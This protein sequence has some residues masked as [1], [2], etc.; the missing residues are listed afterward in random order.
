MTQSDQIKTAIQTLYRDLLVGL[1]LKP[2][3]GQK[4]MIATIA[5][6]LL[7][8][9][10]DD[11]G[12]RLGENP[13]CIVEAGT[14][15]GKTMAYVVACL[16]VAQAM[17]KKLVISTATIALQEQIMAQ[18]LP[19]IKAQG[20]VDFTYQLAKGRRRYVCLSRLGS[21]LAQHDAV[22]PNQALFADELAVQLDSDQQ[23]LYQTMLQM[24][25]DGDWD[26]DRDAWQEALP[27]AHWRPVTTDHRGCTNRRCTHFNECPFFQARAGLEQAECIVTNHDLVLADLQLGGGAILPAPEEVIYVFDEG[28]HLADK[29]LRQFTHQQGVRQLLRWYSQVRTGVKRFAK[30][31]QGGGQG[32]GLSVNIQ[33][34]LQELEA[35]MVELERLLEQPAFKAQ[36]DYQQVA[37]FRFTNGVVPDALRTQ[38]T[39]LSLLTKRLIRDL[40]SLYEVVEGVVKGEQQGLEASLAEA[41]LAVTGAWAQN[42][43]SQD[44]LWQSYASID[45]VGEAPMARWIQHWQTPERVDIELA[46]SPILANKL[47]QQNLWQRCFAALITSATLLAVGRFDQLLMHTGLSKNSSM[48]ALAS[49][50]DYSASSL[51][52][53]EDAVEPGPEERFVQALVSA[54]PKHLDMS[55]ASLVLFTSRRVMQQVFSNLSSRWQ[56]VI[57]QQGDSSKQRL[58]EQHRQRIDDGEGSILFGLASFAEGID[59]PG[60]YL[61]HVVITRLPFTVPD[62]PVPAALAEWIEAGGGNAFTQLSVPE[63]SVRLIQATGRLLRN[64]D[65][66]GRITVLDKRLISKR[67]GK[68]LLQALPPYQHLL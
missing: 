40:D 54:L 55:E 68:Q 1:A 22:D 37:S 10:Q 11:D 47:L 14:G 51:T 61:T 5:N 12:S 25:D 15:T 63:A 49:P 48:L 41:Y 62:R 24:L 16:P 65:D 34:H 46:S 43:L 50:F 39:Q 17:G 56:D 52:V 6:H 13:A 18:D 26:G 44:L 9:R 36:D 42:S 58:L 7:A 4:Q 19:A 29:T 33:A 28:H 38:A 57:L 2:R 59:L 67:Y 21:V 53:P 35:A 23:T 66:K 32:A 64:E 30:D 45:E 8:I 3:W 31:W 60:A 20:K 27:E